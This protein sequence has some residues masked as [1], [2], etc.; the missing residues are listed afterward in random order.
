MTYLV[1][2]DGRIARRPA[3]CPFWPRPF[4]VKAAATI[5]A[6]KAL[7]FQQLPLLG[8][9]EEAAHDNLIG[10]VVILLER[11]L[12]DVCVSRGFGQ[13]RSRRGLSTPHL[14][15]TRAVLKTGEVSGN[16]SLKRRDTG[17]R[18]CP[19]FVSV[20]RTGVGLSPAHNVG[21]PVLCVDAS[22]QDGGRETRDMH[23]T[24][25]TSAGSRWLRPTS[26]GGDDLSPCH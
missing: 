21:S 2:V 14:A 12:R 5:G 24:G 1:V 10:K 16:G 3:R 26:V 6:R 23:A 9:G 4:S 22:S 25:I 17:T 13:T 19:Y 15:S 18:D 7:A 8:L 20:L 11:T